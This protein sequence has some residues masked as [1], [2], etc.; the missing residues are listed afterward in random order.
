MCGE[1]GTSFGWSRLKMVLH[2]FAYHVSWGAE[3]SRTGFLPR[4]HAIQFRSLEPSIGG[5]LINT[6][7]WSEFEP[8]DLIRN[9][10][11]CGNWEMNFDWSSPIP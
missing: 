10:Q 6:G 3:Q 11:I 7:F 2:V 4:V 8:I 1:V 5:E 9:S